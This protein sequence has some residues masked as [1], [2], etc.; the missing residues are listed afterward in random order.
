M[1]PPVLLLDNNIKY[2]TTTIL[3]CISYRQ[4]SLAFSRKGEYD[5]TIDAEAKERI[6]LWITQGKP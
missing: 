3:F 2:I 4:K 6:G 1:F 5:Y